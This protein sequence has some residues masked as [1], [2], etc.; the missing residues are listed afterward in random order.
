[1]TKAELFRDIAQH[2][3]LQIKDVTTVLESFFS[4]VKCQVAQGNKVTIRGFGTFYMRHRKEKV[5]RNIQKETSFIIPE[6]D[7]P[8]FKVSAQ[9]LEND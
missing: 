5:V 2:T 8:T 1:M 6:K 7:I 3:G 9:F 4:A